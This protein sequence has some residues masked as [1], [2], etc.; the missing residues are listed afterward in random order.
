VACVGLACL[1][2]VQAS[3]KSRAAGLAL[4]AWLASVV[5]F[6]LALLALLVVS[7]GNPLERAVYPWLLLLDPVDVF[8]L[9]NLVPLG[10]GAGNEL[11]T[12]MT[13]QHTYSPLLLYAMSLAWAVLPFA[14]AML[15][16]RCK[17]I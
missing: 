2:S 17:E 9:V 3:A 8:R 15:A 6:D 13:G 7:G 16:F 14:L 10:E 12:G 1:I 4:V 11:L 5:L